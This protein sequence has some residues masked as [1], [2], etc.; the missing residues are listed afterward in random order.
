MLTNLGY[1]LKEVSYVSKET[2]VS[3][4]SIHIPCVNEDCRHYY[5]RKGEHCSI[6]IKAKV[7]REKDSN[8]RTIGKKILVSFPTRD[9]SETATKSECIL[10]YVEE[11]LGITSEAGIYSKVGVC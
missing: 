11:I 4:R 3:K 6:E 10:W 5:E 1:E 7:E 9:L 8:K 2:H